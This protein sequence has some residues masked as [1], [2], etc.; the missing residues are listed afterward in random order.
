MGDDKVVE[1]AVI[2]DYVKSFRRHISKYVK[3]DLGINCIV[4]PAKESG[5]IIMFILGKNTKNENQYKSRQETINKTLMKVNPKAFGGNHL[6]Y[7]FRG[8]N[9]NMHHNRIII[10]KG[11]DV[12]HEWDEKSAKRDIDRILSNAQRSNHAN[13]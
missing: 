2:E 9:I 10:V 6:S 12:L 8:T 4:Y 7:R 11:E 1:N 3:P 13:R 5:A